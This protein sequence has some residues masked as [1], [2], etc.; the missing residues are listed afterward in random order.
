MA[1]FIDLFSPETYQAFADSWRSTSGFGL[2]HKTTAEG[3]REA[4][5]WCAI[6]RDCLAGSACWR[7]WKAHSLTVSPS[8]F[9][10]TIRSWSGSVCREKRSLNM[11]KEYP[12][13]CEK[14]P[15]PLSS[16]VAT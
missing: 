3:F 14:V 5:C 11:T 16:R 12:S 6:S 13:R 9:P 10:R 15:E 4:G 7:L 2:R 1:Y 8:S